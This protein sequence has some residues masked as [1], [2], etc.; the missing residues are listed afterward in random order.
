MSRLRGSMHDHLADNFKM[1]QNYVS[2]TQRL[3]G[4][5]SMLY[6]FGFPLQS[7]NRR[8]LVLG[9]WMEQLHIDLRTR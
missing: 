3:W 5:I 1:Q 9:R 8:S 2:V 4:G 6:Y 7:I